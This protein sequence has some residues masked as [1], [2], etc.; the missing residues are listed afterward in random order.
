MQEQISQF[1]NVIQ[2]GKKILIIPQSGSDI[3]QLATAFALANLFQ[4]LGKQTSV[5]LPT[6]KFPK[7]LS[8]LKRNFLSIEKLSGL[9]D[10]LIIFN[11]EKNEIL[12]IKTE[13]K[14]KQTIIRVTPEKETIDPRDFSFVPASYEYD[15][16]ITL[17][18]E[19]LEHLGQLYFS[20][21]D[22]FY[23]LPKI[24]FSISPRTEKFALVNIV[25][26]TAS[27]IGEMLSNILLDKFE[28]FIDPNIA[29]CLLTAI[30]GGTDSFKKA[31]ATPASMIMAA[32]LMKY[33]ADQ[34][35]IIRYLY[36]TKSIAFLKLWG[37][38]MSRLK[39]DEKTQLIWSSALQEDFIQSGALQSD[40]PFVL[41]EIEKNHSSAQ[42]FALLFFNSKG[43]TILK[44]KANDKKYLAKL[45]EQYEIENQSELEINLKFKPIEVVEKELLELISK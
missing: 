24:N 45:C 39:Y 2:S 22:L 36:K 11:T 20:N 15:L 10:F 14:E 28:K 44:I 27:T 7:K 31:T 30:I 42:I 40:I 37:K 29:Q 9:R 35:T 41:E 12:K 3:D 5:F 6:E 38:I 32:R 19:N 21:S 13:K 34:A 1:E 25:D 33:Q 4:K 16:L 8:F 23:E 26:V 18:A 17:G 43:E